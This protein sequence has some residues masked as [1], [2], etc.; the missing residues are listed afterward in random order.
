MTD[1]QAEPCTNPELHS[2]SAI[3]PFLPVLQLR[4]R[5]LQA[6]RRWFVEHDFVEVETPVRLAAPAL[7]LH[8]NAEPAGD[9]FLRTSPELHMKRLIAAGAQRIFQMGPCFRRG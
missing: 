5:V 1:K 8:I 6:I 9:R 2:P 4:S 3:S 7:E